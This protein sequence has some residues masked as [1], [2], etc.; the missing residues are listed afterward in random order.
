MAFQIPLNNI[1]QF[2]HTI[3][4]SLVDL[5]EDMIKIPLGAFP[6]LKNIPM[7]AQATHL[8]ELLYQQFS[9]FTICMCYIHSPLL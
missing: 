3:F 1:E 2:T 7:S 6:Q 9:S 4:K 8:L 5:K